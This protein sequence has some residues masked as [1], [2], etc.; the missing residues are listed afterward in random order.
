M[1]V[2]PRV[3]YQIATIICPRN[4]FR[5]YNV[6]RADGTLLK[7]LSSCGHG[8]NFVGTMSVVPM[9]LYRKNKIIFKWN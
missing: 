1:L 7:L 3:L 6:G 5:G 2:V 9:V 4:K 8:I